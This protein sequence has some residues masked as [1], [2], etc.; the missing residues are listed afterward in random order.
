MFADDNE[1]AG[2][3]AEHDGGGG[4]DGDCGH[5]RRLDE[6]AGAGSAVQGM[7]A[8]GGE[9][10]VDFV[11]HGV[12]HGFFAHRIRAVRVSVEEVKV[13]GL[14]ARSDVLAGRAAF[15][16]QEGQIRGIVRVGREADGEAAESHYSGRKEGWIDG[17]MGALMDRGIGQWGIKGGGGLV[18]WGIGGRVEE[19]NGRKVGGWKDDGLVG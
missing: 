7:D 14:C 10:G 19:W 11:A 9:L 3:A 1:D 6:V 17:L 5:V 2:F 8:Q 16:A 12:M 18:E 13:A 15:E 4:I